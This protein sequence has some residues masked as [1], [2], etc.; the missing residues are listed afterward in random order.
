MNRIIK[1]IR[2]IILASAGLIAA[3]LICGYIGIT[4]GVSLLNLAVVT[5]LGPSGLGLLLI[6]R[7]V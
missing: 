3:D 4:L 2:S 7:L 6:M 1:L 5:I